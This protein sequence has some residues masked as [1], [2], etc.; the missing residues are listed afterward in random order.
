MTTPLQ[1][2]TNME[3]LKNWQSISDAPKNGEAIYTHDGA[4]P[5]IAAWCSWPNYSFE[6]EGPWWDR[7]KVK[8][9]KPN[10]EGWYAVYCVRGKWTASH[11]IF[12]SLW[13]PLPKMPWEC[14]PTPSEE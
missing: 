11:Q 12:P 5:V 9:E 1:E 6:E 13:R 4:N 10:T 14:I 3:E 8:V 2:K 7:K